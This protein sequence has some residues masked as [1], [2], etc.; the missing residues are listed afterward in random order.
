MNIQKNEKLEL[1]L[2]KIG[3]HYNAKCDYMFK[4]IQVEGKP[5]INATCFY[6]NCKF[7]FTGDTKLI[8]EL[9]KE[10]ERE[11]IKYER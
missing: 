4:T 2:E 6:E 7:E 10:L 9:K 8:E 3:Y 5:R 1:Q 11:G